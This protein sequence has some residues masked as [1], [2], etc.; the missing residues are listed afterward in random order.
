M[1]TERLCVLNLAE[2]E[3]CILW[4]FFIFTTSAK[5]FAEVNVSISYQ[6][7][8]MYY[9]M[10]N[11]DFMFCTM[12]TINSEDCGKLPMFENSQLIWIK[13]GLYVFVCPCCIQWS[14]LGS[15]E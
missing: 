3:I 1:P 4:G 7:I 12:C 13:F 9:P 15:L 11:G 10:Y 6:K 2:P 5:L 8:I 14:L